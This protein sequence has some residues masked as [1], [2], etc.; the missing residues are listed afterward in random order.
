MPVYTTR[1]VPVY[2]TKV[3]P[4]YTTREVPVYEI[5]VT[6]I[7]E[8]ITYYRSRTREYISGNVDI[9]WSRSQNDLTLIKKGYSLT[10]QSRI[11]Q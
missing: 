10:G 5:K 3:V 8:N 11:A 1:E 2:E 9:K 4:V 7:Y 6:P